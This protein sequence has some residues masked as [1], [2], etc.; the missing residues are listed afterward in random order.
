M[1]VFQGPALD[2]LVV[3]ART[4]EEGVAWCERVL[5]MTPAA[6]GQHPLFGTH[7]RLMRLHG[8]EHMGSYLE[9]IAIEAGALPSRSAP[10]RRWFDLDDE[11]LQRRLDMQGPQLVHWVARVPDISAAVQGLRTLGIERGPVIHAARPTANG[12]LQWQ[13]TVRDD[14]QR[15]FDGALPTLIQWN[16]RHPTESLPRPGAQLHQLTLTHPEAALL[17]QALDLLG[18]ASVKVEEGPPRMV[19]TLSTVARSGIE[20]KHPPDAVPK[21]FA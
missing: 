7:N 11:T 16:G 9:I 15:L 12:L 2:H 18:I 21:S 14:G 5:G 4:L 6:G 20:L 8:S 1:S 13:I 19:A 17:R 3:A 10:L